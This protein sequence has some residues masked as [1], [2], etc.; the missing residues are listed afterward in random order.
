MLASAL[1][2]FAVCPAAALAHA[3]RATVFSVDR[4]HHT[5]ELVDGGHLV[6][7]YAYRGALPRL[8]LGDKISFRRSGHAISRVKKTA[9]AS[10]TVAF[11]ARV[12]G[13]SSGRLQLRLTDGNTFS[14]S[15]KPVSA[16][17]AAHHATTTRSSAP[18][19]GAA[20]VTVQIQ[21][22]TPGLTVLISEAVDAQGHW[23]ITITLPPAAVSGGTIASGNDPSD[24]DKVTEGT[25]KQVSANR[26]AIDTGSG[27]LAFSVDPGS[28]LTDGFLVGDVVDVTYAQNADGSFGADDVEYVEQDASGPVTA[29]SDS[30]ITVADQAS[31]I[32][33]TITADPSLGLFVGVL[34]GDQVDVAYH[35]C[36]AGLVADAV[37]DQSWDG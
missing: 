33:Y 7:A 32:S 20:P 27:L 10:G 3:P 11:Y 5:I 15:S 14:L 6:H 29:V 23:T 17:A 1:A 8:G 31:G 18:S 13:A 35:Q 12:V 16:R 24:D 28:G 36:A 4:G 19:A 34:P 37:D 9:R 21:G 22:L 30:R 25:I 2:T 26:V